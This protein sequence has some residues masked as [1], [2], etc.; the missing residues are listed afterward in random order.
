MHFH[1]SSIHDS[2]FFSLNDQ[3]MLRSCYKMS[4]WKINNNVWFMEKRGQ[5]P[6]TRHSSLTSIKFGGWWIIGGGN[7]EVSSNIISAKYH[8]SLSSCLTWEI[9]SENPLHTDYDDKENSRFF[10]KDNME[11]WQVICEQKIL[12]NVPQ[13]DGKIPTYLFRKAKHCILLRLSFSFSSPSD[14]WGRRA[15]VLLLPPLF[16]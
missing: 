4:F 2:E 13:N 1:I 11:V 9:Q 16:S 3:G 15:R 7:C 14:V 6:T 5:N 8:P 10:H 12:V